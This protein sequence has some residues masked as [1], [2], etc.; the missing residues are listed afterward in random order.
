[1]KCN[2]LLDAGDN[3]VELAGYLVQIKDQKPVYPEWAKYDTDS[4]MS[5]NRGGCILF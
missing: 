3:L 2:P 4:T 5:D 1:M